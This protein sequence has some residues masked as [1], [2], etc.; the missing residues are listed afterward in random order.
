[1]NTVEGNLCQVVSRLFTFPP[2]LLGVTARGRGV[3]GGLVRRVQTKDSTGT[4][5]VPVLG[6]EVEA[7]V[8][9]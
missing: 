4:I 3:G 6:T 1:M 5:G 7:S 9:G 2:F 8:Q